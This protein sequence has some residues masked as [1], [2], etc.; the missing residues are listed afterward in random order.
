MTALARATSN[1]KRQTSP[2]VRESATGQQT[3]NCLAVIKNLVVGPRWVLYLTQIP[4][5]ES[6]VPDEDGES[7]SSRQGK[8]IAAEARELGL[9]VQNTTRGQPVKN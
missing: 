3:R 7:D 2:L 9:G 4:N 1:C 6:E 8:I 5:E